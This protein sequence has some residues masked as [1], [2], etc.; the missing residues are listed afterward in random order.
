[1]LLTESALLLFESLPE[2]TQNNFDL[3]TAAFTENY[4]IPAANQ[5]QHQI[6]ALQF[7]QKQN[8]PVVEFVLETKFRIKNHG[9]NENQQ[10]AIFLN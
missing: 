6:E 1:M 7:V 10:A 4:I 8:E 2:A 5:L 9:F 3:L